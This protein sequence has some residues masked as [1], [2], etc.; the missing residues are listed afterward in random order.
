[1]TYYSHDFDYHG[2]TKVRGPRQGFICDE[3]DDEKDALFWSTETK[4]PFGWFAWRKW[5]SKVVHHWC[6]ECARDF[7][8]GARRA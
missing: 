1:V 3:C 7:C 4:P 6:P 2:H 8:A 5:G